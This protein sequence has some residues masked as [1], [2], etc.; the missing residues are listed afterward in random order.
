MWGIPRN[1]EAEHEYEA[2]LRDRMNYRGYYNIFKKA[3]RK[4]EIPEN[5]TRPY[6]LRHTRLTEVATFMGYE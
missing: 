1:H 5:K 2:D 6:N 4:A 3:C